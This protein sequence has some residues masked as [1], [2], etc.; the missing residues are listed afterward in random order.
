MDGLFG[1]N[2]IWMTPVDEEK[3]AFQ[4]TKGI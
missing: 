2:Q 1:Y 4:T 3:T